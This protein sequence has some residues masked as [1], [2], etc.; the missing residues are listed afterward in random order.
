MDAKYLSYIPRDDIY[1]FNTGNATKAWLCYGCTYI[2]ELQVHRFVVW[3]PNARRVSLVGEFNDWNPDAMPMEAMEGGIWV[4]FVEGL[5]DCLCYK[6]C[7]D[8]APWSGASILSPG[9]TR[10]ICESVLSAIS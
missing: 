6:Y 2:P 5:R 3:A 4:I 1:L 10:S 9:G 7:I 8:G